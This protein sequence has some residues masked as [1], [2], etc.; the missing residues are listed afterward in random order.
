MLSEISQMKINI[1]LF[2][3]YVEFKV[4]QTNEQM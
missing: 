1:I 4:M 2:H 3:L